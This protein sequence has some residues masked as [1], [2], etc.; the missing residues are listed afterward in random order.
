[1]FKHSA[2]NSE[3]HGNGCKIVAL[4][5]LRDQPFEGL[6]KVSERNAQRG[7]VEEPR[8]SI[9]IWLPLILSFIEQHTQ[10]L[11]TFHAVVGTILDT[12]IDVPLERPMNLLQFHGDSIYK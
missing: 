1:M 2:F 11:G 3:L 6:A 8:S 9:D 7:I 5:D 12:S 4:T 10:H